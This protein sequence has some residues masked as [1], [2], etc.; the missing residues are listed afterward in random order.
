[1]FIEVH[2]EKTAN[3][4]S[5]F[6]G[7]ELIAVKSSYVGL[8]LDLTVVARVRYYLWSPTGCAAL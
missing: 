6:F 8:V 1:M 4:E 2:L 3:R 7:E 5:G